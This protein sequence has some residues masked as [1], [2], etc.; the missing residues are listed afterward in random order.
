MDGRYVDAV[1]M[2]YLRSEWEAAS[3]ARSAGATRSPRA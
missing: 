2:G 1:V 3:A